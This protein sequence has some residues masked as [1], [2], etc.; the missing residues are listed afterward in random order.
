MAADETIEWEKY[1]YAGSVRLAIPLH[2]A[3]GDFLREDS[4]SA[5]YLI[6]DHLGSTSMVI[7]TS[8]HEVAK[9]YYLTFRDSLSGRTSWVASS[10]TSAVQKARWLLR[11]HQA[12]AR[13]RENPA[14][15]ASAQ[16]NCQP[17]TLTPD[18]AKL[19]R[20]G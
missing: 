14:P 13:V 2:G 5:L 17:T 15:E 10:H 19:Q 4:D 16:R 12:Y 8:G 18:S 9:R 7:D 1:Y 20:L 11:P 6:T 3:S